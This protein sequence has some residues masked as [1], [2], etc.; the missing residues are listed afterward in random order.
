MQKYKN[1][2]R[3]ANF[4]VPLHAFLSYVDGT[5]LYISLMFGVL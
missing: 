3:Y 2:L 4:L 1:I 5:G